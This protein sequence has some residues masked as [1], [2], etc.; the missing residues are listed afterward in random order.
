MRVDRGVLFG[1]ILFGLGCLVGASGS[2]TSIVSGQD[3]NKVETAEDKVTVAAKAVKEA[4]DALAAEQKY[5]TITDAPN[6]FLVLGGGGNGTQDLEA[7]VVDP[8]TFAALYAGA[9]KKEVK[10]QLQKD[11]QGRITYNGTVIR[12]YPKSRLERIFAERLKSGGP[13]P[14]K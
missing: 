2:L 11:E 14:P 9:V 6:S 13:T 1:G 7:G 4:A 10:D 8:E 3:A 5:E 12:M